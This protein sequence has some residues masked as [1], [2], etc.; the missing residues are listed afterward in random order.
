[1]FE[2]H[3]YYAIFLMEAFEHFDKFITY[4]TIIIIS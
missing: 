2:I 1:M 4:F 3:L